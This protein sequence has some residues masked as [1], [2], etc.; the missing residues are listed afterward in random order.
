MLSH[1][2]VSRADFQVRHQALDESPNLFDVFDAIVNDEDLAAAPDFLVD[3][4]TNEG[5]IE[6]S[7]VSL[8]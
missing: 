7:D 5:F 6:T 1:L 2:P 8:H 4:V 3:R